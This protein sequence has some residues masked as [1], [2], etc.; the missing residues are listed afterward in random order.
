M[1]IFKGQKGAFLGRKKCT[2]NAQKKNAQMCVIK[3]RKKGHRKG[4]KIASFT[5]EISGAP[6]DAIIG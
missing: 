3:T 5:G 1:A 6:S 4:L 2:Q